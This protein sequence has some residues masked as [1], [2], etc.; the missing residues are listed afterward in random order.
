MF[1][2]PEWFRGTSLGA[3]PAPRSVKGWA[4]YAICFAGILGPAILLVARQQIFPEAAIWLAIS[5]LAFYL[6]VRGLK[7]DLRESEARSNMYFIDD[8]SNEVVETDQYELKIQ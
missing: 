8:A 4:F 3:I 6:E 5:L 2:N 7:R 1:A